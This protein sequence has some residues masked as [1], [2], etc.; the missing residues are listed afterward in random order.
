MNPDQVQKIVDTIKTLNINVNDATTQKL[1]DAVIPV[2][3][4]YIWQN[5]VSMGLQ[6]VAGCV[7]AFTIYKIVAKIVEYN[8]NNKE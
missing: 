7:A 2:V 1:A 3:R 4:M 8:K 6:L 5:Y